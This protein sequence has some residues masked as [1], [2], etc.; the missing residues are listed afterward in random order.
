MARPGTTLP[1]EHTRIIVLRSS[2]DAFDPP[3]IGRIRERINK[4]SNDRC[5]LL[6]NSADFSVIGLVV[7]TNR[8]V[9]YIRNTLD[10][11][12]NIRNLGFVL[13]L[14]PTDEWTGIGNGSGA[15]HLQRFLSIP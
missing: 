3:L 2:E 6:F 7:R 10:E 9:G 4:I 12:L 5:E 8:P 1:D 13:I 15:R 11:G 14:S